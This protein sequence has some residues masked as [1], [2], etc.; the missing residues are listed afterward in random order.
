MAVSLPR[1]RRLR[2]AI[3][4]AVAVGFILCASGGLGGVGLLYMAPAV[5]M[6]AMLL[7]RR[8]P[9]ERLLLRLAA[10]QRRRRRPR[11]AEAGRG[12]HARAV[13][14]PRGGLLMG[15]ALAVRP[16]PRFCTAS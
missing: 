1:N 5:A 9:G 14:V 2:V 6:L 16:P 10:R 8:Y 11:P 12:L 3:A 7:A 4:V 15:F 13:H